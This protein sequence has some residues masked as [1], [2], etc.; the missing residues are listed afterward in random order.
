L[1]PVRTFPYGTLFNINTTG[2]PSVIR[3]ACID[4]LEQ[5]SQKHER[6]D[7]PPHSDHLCGENILCPAQCQPRALHWSQGGG[8]V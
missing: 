1:Q 6:I 2:L 8:R 4:Q 5:N 3:V 7:S